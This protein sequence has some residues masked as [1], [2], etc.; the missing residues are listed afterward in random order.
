MIL[1]EYLM[2]IFV[3]FLINRYFIN[4]FVREKRNIWGDFN[5]FIENLKGL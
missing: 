5:K 1:F 2:G 3:S 4:L